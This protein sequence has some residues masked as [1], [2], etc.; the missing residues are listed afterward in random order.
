MRKLRICLNLKSTTALAYSRRAPVAV[1]TATMD[2]ATAVL[3][4]IVAL[5]F[6]PAPALP[7]AFAGEVAVA[8]GPPS[9]LLGATLPVVW[10]R[11]TSAAVIGTDGANIRRWR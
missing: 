2:Q 1:K 9:E 7:E 5:P 6:P 3:S 4:L 8:T 11:R 10:N